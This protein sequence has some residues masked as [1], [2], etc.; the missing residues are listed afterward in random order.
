MFLEFM[1]GFN[2][3]SRKLSNNDQ[4]LDAIQGHIP[5]KGELMGFY[6]R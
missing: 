1:H 2:T 4:F 3:R 5:T 6:K